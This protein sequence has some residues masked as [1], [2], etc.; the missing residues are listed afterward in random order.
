[1]LICMTSSD[2]IF[3]LVRQ[4]AFSLR[5]DACFSKN[6]S[7]IGSFR[8]NQ[9]AHQLSLIT[10]CD[11]LGGSSRANTFVQGEN[12][13]RDKVE[14]ELFALSMQVTFIRRT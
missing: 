10:N 12:R 7:D 11:K 4:H 1:M 14:W 2:I 8:T 9:L 3:L 5:V 6:I 13:S